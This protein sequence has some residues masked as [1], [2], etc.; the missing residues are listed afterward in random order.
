MLLHVLFVPLQ[1]SQL[2]D[3]NSHLILMLSC[4]NMPLG[5]T[6]AGSIEVFAAVDALKGAVISV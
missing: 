3:F 2:T 6:S 5:E 4:V 1:L